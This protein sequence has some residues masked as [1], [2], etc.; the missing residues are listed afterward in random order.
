M[1]QIIKLTTQMATQAITT[2]IIEKIIQAAKDA[3]EE[4]D[5]D[6]NEFFT[7]EN[8]SN[9]INKDKM[10]I[11]DARKA[12]NI[13]KK[14]KTK[15][16]KPKKVNRYTL[17]CKEERVILKDDDEWSDQPFV[18]ISRE[19]GRRWRILNTDQQE[20][21]NEKAKSFNESINDDSDSDSSV[22]KTK[23]KKTK[24]KKKKTKKK[25]KKKSDSDSDSES[26]SESDSQSESESD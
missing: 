1:E 11:S 24:K 26:E 6:F 22:S 8:I 16:D 21:W 18:E 23:K 5:F 15:S 12:L 7:S 20:D 17:F 14:K 3:N 25:K 10:K 13:T 4:D 19:L 9:I 2:T